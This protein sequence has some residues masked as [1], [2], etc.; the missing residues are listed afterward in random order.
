MARQNMI[1]RK[2]EAQL[3]A[4]GY[5]NRIFFASDTGR[6]FQDDGTSWNTVTLVFRGAYS[7]AATYK[8]FD[9]ITHLGSAWMTL[10]SSITNTTPTEG[11]NFTVFAAKG[12]PGT[13]GTPGTP[14][15]TGARGLTPR[16]SWSSAI[17][18]S[19]DDLVLYTDG[20]QWRA[21]AT[22]TNVVPAENASWTL[23]LQKGATG[24]T[25]STAAHA[26]SHVTGGAD[27]IPAAVA[28]GNAGLF[29]GAEKTKLN[30]LPSSAI[31]TTEKGAASGVASLDASTKVPAAQLPADAV[32]SVFT[33]TGAIVAA[34]GDYTAD[35]ITNTPAGLIIATNVQAA[36]NE[37][38]AEKQALTQK[39]QASG[40]AGL[41]SNTRLA[42]AQLGSGTP[43][44][45]KYL[46]G[47][48]SWSA[49]PGAAGPGFS[50]H[51]TANQT[52]MSTSAPTKVA[53]NVEEWDPQAYF[54][55]TTNFRFLP[56]AAGYYQFQWTVT[57]SASALVNSWIYKNGAEER[58]GSQSYYATTATNPSSSGS[59][60]V[61]LNGTTDYVELWAVC[62]S[63]TGIGTKSAMFLQGR[64]V[65]S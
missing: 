2:P 43:D 59:A 37:L 3:P 46:R 11:A 6:V 60:T 63:G 30:A 61:Y 45:T 49:P 65:A 35:K 64:L 40:Y 12:D 7:A 19:L 53:L 20:N 55:A 24:A 57:G 28:G 22:S 41:D 26:A 62:S 54:D 32:P 47:D 5:P 36:L 44:N 8:R 38:D 10:A 29:T 56:L 16:G 4:A 42:L 52:G 33:R 58:R 1:Q 51:R 25:G 23:F 17:T 21:L 48:G 18:Y 27:V 14:G 31:P 13:P 50:A 15:A 34:A 9:I 39:D